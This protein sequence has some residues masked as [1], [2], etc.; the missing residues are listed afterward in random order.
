MLNGCNCTWIPGY[1][2]FVH[3]ARATVLQADGVI[4]IYIQTVKECPGLADCFYGCL[5]FKTHIS[6][7]EMIWNVPKSIFIRLAPY[8]TDLAFEV[9]FQLFIVWT[10]WSRIVSHQW[11]Q[12]LWS[13]TW[14]NNCD[15]CWW[16]RVAGMHGKNA[17]YVS[18]V[19]LVSVY[20]YNIE[21]YIL[22]L[23]HCRNRNPVYTLRPMPYGGWFKV[24]I[25]ICE[26]IWCQRKRRMGPRI[27]FH[28]S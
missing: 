11:L 3:R 1:L 19:H 2:I 17:M 25:V 4:T 26:Q 20:V 24:H 14:L 21:S 12:W 15:Q 10:R 5:K 18:C 7:T 22:C 27:W 23:I 8:M 6:G 13:N 9:M 16:S 28:L